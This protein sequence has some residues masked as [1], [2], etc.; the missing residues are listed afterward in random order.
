[1]ASLQSRTGG[2]WETY[3]ALL[4]ARHRLSAIKAAGVLEELATRADP[5]AF[6]L[7]ERVYADLAPVHG[8]PP[9]E[10]H[11]AAMILGLAT[12]GRARDALT[13]ARE[14]GLPVPF[15]AVAEAAA[16][17]EPDAFDEVVAT[18]KA[19]GQLSE[20]LYAPRFA[21]LLRRPVAP[22]M[23]DVDSIA[24][25]M[26]ADGLSLGPWC[27]VSLARVYLLLGE[28]S[29]AAE[30]VGAWAPES[31]EPELAAALYDATLAVYMKLR[32][33]PAVERVVGAMSRTF[34][35]PGGEY[36]LTLEYLVRSRLGGDLSNANSVIEAADAVARASAR[37]FP[38]SAWQRLI[39]GA[40]DGPGGLQ[41]A[42]EVYTA[43]RSRATVIDKT[44]AQALITALAWP[45][46]ADGIARTTP[47]LAEAMEV[48]G[49]LITAADGDRSIAALQ[50]TVGVVVPLLRAC[51]LQGTD[52]HRTALQLLADA[53]DR[54]VPFPG[55]HNRGYQITRLVLE[56]MGGSGGHEEAHEVYR[57]VRAA[58]PYPLSQAEHSAIIAQFLKLEFRDSNVSK[59]EFVFSMMDDMRA[60]GYR[61]GTLILTTLLSKYAALCKR[62][63]KTYK[64]QP[65]ELSFRLS[66]FLAATRDVHA[67]VSLDAMIEM[68]VPLLTALMDALS[69][70]GAYEEAIEVWDEIVR[71]RQDTPP[72]AAV[73]LF[74]PSIS[75]ALDTCGWYGNLPRAR[76]IWAW[77]T[78]HELKTDR[79]YLA[80]VECLCRCGQLDEALDLITG[81][82]RPSKDICV[83][84]LKLYYDSTEIDRIKETIKHRFPEWWDE[85]T[86]IVNLKP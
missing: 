38:P 39:L 17:H 56:L 12:A 13:F 51:A 79:H 5:R 64:Y 26:D 24:A 63:K 62:T 77:A 72:E 53:K 54:G 23:A 60:A 33:T 34:G 28:R 9:G 86:V 84:P 45:P 16:L 35:T 76:K 48:Y 42:F 40:L 2:I 6:S 81:M 7:L 21:A 69:S 52:A 3:F 20:R 8:F 1:M 11:N 44:L 41:T 47:R 36:P 73:E 71:R 55:V 43:A 19:E 85:L 75:V 50:P 68:S 83:I 25:A 59:P 29:R 10:R 80:W 67:L 27:E 14:T 37:D 30:L 49:D 78:R 4:G 31:A 57:A 66:A 18:A 65:T 74:G 22:S 46:T 32:D 61:P 58:W 70:A 82:L 15:Q